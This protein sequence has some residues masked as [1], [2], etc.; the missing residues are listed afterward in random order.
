MHTRAPLHANAGPKETSDVGVGPITCPSSHDYPVALRGKQNFKCCLMVPQ[1]LDFSYLHIKL[2]NL[3]YST[4]NGS[5]DNGSICLLVQFLVNKTAEPLSGFD[6]I[7]E[8]QGILERPSRGRWV[9]GCKR[10]YVNHEIIGKLRTSF[11]VCIFGEGS[12][13][14][15]TLVPTGV[16]RTYRAEK[17]SWYV[18]A[19]SF[20]LLLLNFSAWPCLGAA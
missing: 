8:S 12:H 13:P 6:C 11:R 7:R 10:A 17:K 14:S 16:L 19:R 5:P 20:F 1:H 3:T 4:F 9:G 15:P 2:T 18:V